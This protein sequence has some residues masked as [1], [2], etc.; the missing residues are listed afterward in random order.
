MVDLPGK[1]IKNAMD[2]RVPRNEAALTF[3]TAISIS[4]TT[5][6]LIQGEK[7]GFSVVKRSGI[8]V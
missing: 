2:A 7:T 6:H 8:F 4:L 5:W 1:A 3:L